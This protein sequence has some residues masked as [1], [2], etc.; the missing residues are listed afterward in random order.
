MA[1]PLLPPQFLR[2][3]ADYHS[4]G[5]FFRALLHDEPLPTDVYDGYDSIAIL[6]AAQQAAEEHREVPV[7]P[8]ARKG[9]R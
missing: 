9:T 1:G 6:A 8:W 2:H 7:R 5:Q 4:P 3:E